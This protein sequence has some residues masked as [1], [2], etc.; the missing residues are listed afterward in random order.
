[1]L[2]LREVPKGLLVT[3]GDTVVT[4]GYSDIFPS[5]LMV[6]TVS[7]VIEKPENFFKEIKV[8]PAA[9]MSKLKE[10]FILLNAVGLTEIIP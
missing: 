3:I 7:S 8:K 6:G 1:M 5:G 9:S 2:D 10:V 4:S